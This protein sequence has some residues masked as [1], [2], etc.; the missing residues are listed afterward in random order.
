MSEALKTY[1]SLSAKLP[2]T[3]SVR[4]AAA[5]LVQSSAMGTNEEVIRKANGWLLQ[6]ILEM[7]LTTDDGSTSVDH[8]SN[9]NASEDTMYADTLNSKNYTVKAL[10]EIAKRMG[11]KRYSALRKADLANLIAE[12]IEIPVILSTEVEAD[13]VP[14]S[15]IMEAVKAELAAST[16]VKAPQMAATETDADEDA[17]L[18]VEEIVTAYTNMKRTWNR[19]TGKLALSLMTK[20]IK[21][22]TEVKA[23]GFNP[24][25]VGMGYSV[26]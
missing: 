7:G 16:P 6:E 1:Y 2:R 9:D 19:A 23:M 13:I 8:N 20:L 18:T 10:K 24:V 26:A 5:S 21:M 15:E 17:P 22:R 25:A 4:A 14:I 12:N 11:L 3:N